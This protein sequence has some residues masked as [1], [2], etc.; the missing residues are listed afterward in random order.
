MGPPTNDGQST[1]V[2]ANGHVWIND[3]RWV[4]DQRVINNQTGMNGQ[5]VIYFQ[6]GIH[7]D[8]GMPPAS[9]E[10][11]YLGKRPMYDNSHEWAV[12]SLGVML[13]SVTVCS[14]YAGTLHPTVDITHCAT[15]HTN[16]TRK[17]QTLPRQHGGAS[18]R[19]PRV[20]AAVKYTWLAGVPGPWCRGHP[21]TTVLKRFP[22]TP[23]CVW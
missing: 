11:T 10:R 8:S 23:Q 13:L 5:R 7:D 9:S 19:V 18:E 4:S 6:C 3:R 22:R 2:G 21:Q 14:D 12:P 16:K 20:M 1:E 15:S 17:H